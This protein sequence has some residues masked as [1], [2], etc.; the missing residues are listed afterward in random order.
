MSAHKPNRYVEDFAFVIYLFGN[1]AL[2]S[3][4][5]ILLYNYYKKKAMKDASRS[6]QIMLMLSSLL[7]AQWTI[8]DGT[9]VGAGGFALWDDAHEFLDW[10]CKFEAVLSCIVWTACVLLVPPSKKEEAVVPWCGKWYWLLVWCLIGPALLIFNS[11]VWGADV[12]PT[13]Y[14]FICPYNMAMDT[15]ALVPQLLILRSA[16]NVDAEPPAPW[17]GHIVAM[18]SFCHLSRVVFWIA[19]FWKGSPLFSFMFPDLVGVLIMSDFLWI[20]MQVLKVHLSQGTIFDLERGIHDSA[21]NSKKCDGG[22]EMKGSAGP[23]DH[24]GKTRAPSFDS[25][26][27]PVGYSRAEQS[28]PTPKVY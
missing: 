26:G 22:F 2:C 3:C 4:G 16:N 27:Y 18:L 10:P 25:H 13:L 15:F 6:L 11:A 17:V 8:G 23:F 9:G 20:Y 12:Y 5:G 19:F 24:V 1:L 7:R 28:L 21:A 14:A